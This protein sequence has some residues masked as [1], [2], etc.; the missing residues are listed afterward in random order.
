MTEERAGR[1]TLPIETGIDE[2]VRALVERLGA[3]AVRNSDG[4][5]LPDWVDRGFAK[6]YST[7]FP[8]RG[9]EEW[10]DMSAGE[11]IHQYLLSER[12]TAPPSGP[13][14]I[15]VMEGWF[16]AQF[17]PDTDCDAKRWWQVIDRTA[18]RVLDP[19]EWE[20]E[21]AD[22]RP[23]VDPVPLVGP[24][25]ADAGSALVTIAHP[26]PLH[27]YTVSF[28][29][30][31]I[32]DSTQMYNYLTNDWALDPSR[33]K[34]RPY[35]VEYPR[36]WA[37]VKDALAI[38]LKQNPHVDVVRFTT[39]FYHF[40]LAFDSRG[41][42]RYVDWFGYSASVSVPAME[43][44]EK[45]YGYALTAEDF[46]D[47][48]WYNSP[49][50]PLS[51]R[52]RDWIDFTSRRVADKA[53]T[54]VDMT[55][56]AGRE[57]M[58]FL[59]DNWIGMEPYGKHFPGIGMDAVVG[60]V[61]SAATCRMIA[62]I[63]GV[64]Y[65]EGRFLP[66]F[67]PDVFREGGNPVAEAEESWRTARR[68]IV[69]KPLDRIGYGGYLSLALKFPE[70]I[71]RVESI[72][73]EFRSL[74]SA[75]GGHLPANTRVRVGV[76]N[77]WGSLRTWQ[78]HMVAHALWYKQIH[79]YLGVIESLAGLPFSVEF[80]SFEDVESNPSALDR[81]DVLINAGAANTSFSGGP[82]WASQKL[83]RAI[84]EFV[85]NG[86]GIIGIGEPTAWVGEAAD[87]GATTPASGSVFT[88]SDVLGVD[89]EISWSLSTDRY[90][91]VFPEHFITEDLGEE[92]AS[93]EDP[94]DVVALGARIHRLERGS[95]RLATHEYGAGR[96]V[97]MAGLTW[98][99]LN[100]RLLHRALMWAGGAE[101]EW[102]SVLITTNPE[103]EVAWYP[104]VRRAFV[105]NGSDEPQETRILGSGLV[106][107]DAGAEDETRIDV[108][109]SLGAGESVWLDLRCGEGVT[110]T[111]N[112]MQ[113]DD[114]GEA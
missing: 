32:W 80:L 1:L 114:N 44:F 105:Y 92:F 91:E 3:D 58:M 63:P 99:A 103:V 89:R 16:Q 88:L 5:C 29:A 55:H 33:V 22:P 84:R 97:Y 27:V 31:Q 76:L 101:G 21:T 40:T 8:A 7:Y 37:H 10:A 51:P 2:E 57:A 98:S 30:V 46:V 61:G 113:N 67:F 28:L 107:G 104:Q 111:P 45:E 72:V 23:L 24:L 109:V 65:T 78:T 39:F 106:G 75:S 71:D 74:H 95:V 15:D 19:E 42:E 96:A 54:L 87:R 77:A 53:K 68:A 4:T 110:R 64:R 26:E 83:Q 112:R 69:R 9:D 70:F 81:I 94:G 50:R 79:T 82:A 14:V 93:G 49:F 17:R 56:R 11:R 85:W 36:T 100:S 60:S 62:D 6:V 43:A 52:F 13:L 102:E 90:P 34:E 18:G 41:R 20:V 25:P 73:A 66:Y 35:D 47:A 86:G 59:G 48:G 108:A 12:R 38:W